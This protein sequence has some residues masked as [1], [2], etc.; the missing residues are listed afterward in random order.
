MYTVRTFVLRDVFV[1]VDVE[2]GVGVHGDTHLTDV[3]VDLVRLMSKNRNHGE[4]GESM[5]NVESW[6]SM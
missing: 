3:R 5:E 6:E 1:W 2:G 4:S